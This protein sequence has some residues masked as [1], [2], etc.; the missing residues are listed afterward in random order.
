MRWRLKMVDIDNN[1]GKEKRRKSWGK[2]AYNRMYRSKTAD[3]GGV[4]GENKRD[5]KIRRSDELDRK[6]FGNG[7]GENKNQ[8]VKQNREKKEKKEKRR[9]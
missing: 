7:E 2:G 4:A 9:E 6:D 1:L 8:T 3:Q 5:Q